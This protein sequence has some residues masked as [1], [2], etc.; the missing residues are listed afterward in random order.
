M[1][2]MVNKIKEWRK[3]YKMREKYCTGNRFPFYDLA[4]KYLPSGSNAVIVDIGAGS[5]SFCKY[6]GLDKNIKI[7]ICWME[8]R[9]Q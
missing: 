9:I 5:G 3:E 6:L 2:N 4:G 1:A 8:T 7:F